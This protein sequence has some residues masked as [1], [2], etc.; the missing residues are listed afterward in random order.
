[1]RVTRKVCNSFGIDLVSFLVIDP[2]GKI[3]GANMVSIWGR[4]ESGGPNDGSINFAIWGC[5]FSH[6][7]A[8]DNEQNAKAQHLSN[9]IVS[10]NHFAD[11]IS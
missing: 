7:D 10:L 3:H 5:S 1:M 6:P 9:D 2:E 4:Q 8:S 11:S